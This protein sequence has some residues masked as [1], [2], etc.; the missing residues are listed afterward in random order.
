ML[1]VLGEAWFSKI[2]L[3]LNISALMNLSFPDDVHIM[4]EFTNAEKREQVVVSAPKK[5]LEDPLN[6][7]T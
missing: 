7:I 5:V 4:L 1:K 3:C 6:T 2:G